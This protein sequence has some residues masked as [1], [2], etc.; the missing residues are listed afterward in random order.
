MLQA[1][2]MIPVPPP[3][4]VVTKGWWGSPDQY[5]TAEDLERA[6]NERG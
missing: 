4:Q 6:E 2:G 5:E 1:N 3:M